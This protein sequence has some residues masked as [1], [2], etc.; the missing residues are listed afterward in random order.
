MPNANIARQSAPA[1]G[2]LTRMLGWDQPAESSLLTMNPFALMRRLTADMERALGAPGPESA[3]IAAWR[4]DI[5]V[6]EE[7]GKLVVKAD[8]P[9]VKQEDIKVSAA[10][11]TLTVEGERSHE[12]EVKE[13]GYFRSER[14]YGRFCRMIPL[15][16]GANMDQISANFA[17]G[18]LEVKIPVPEMA[19]RRKEIP[20]QGAQKGKTNAS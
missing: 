4:P 2:P 7:E 10:D 16:E 20:V 13:S 19:K 9:G 6:R 15:P 14:A 18:V 12:K 11:G 5:E 1:A 3:E 8:L 17:N